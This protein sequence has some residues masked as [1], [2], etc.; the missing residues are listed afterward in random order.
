MPWTF[1]HPAAILPLRSIGGFRLPL[2][3]LV[4]GSL[5]P[6]FG[7]YLGLFQLATFAHSSLG[8]LLFCLPAGAM[9][10]ALFAAVR[11]DLIRLLPQPHRGAL[12]SSTHDGRHTSNLRNLFRVAIGLCAGAA[13]HVV[14]DS[15]THASGLAV[16]LLPALQ[17]PVLTVGSRQMHVY[18]LLQHASTVVGL[19]AIMV[20]YQ[21]WLRQSRPNHQTNPTE[22]RGRYLVLIGCLALACTSGVLLAIATTTPPS[23]ASSLDLFRVVILSTNA[24]AVLLFL[25]A[26]VWRRRGDA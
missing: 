2:A 15:F 11:H 25:S 14:W 5:T 17:T 6:D 4:V 12:R 20:V 22:E 24:F 13:T 26:I 9:V 21:R 7:Y 18:N 23:T 8:I 3:A 19:V 16:H 1:A 10:F